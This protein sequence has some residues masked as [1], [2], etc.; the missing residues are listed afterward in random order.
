MNTR[1]TE[2]TVG[3]QKVR[4]GAYILSSIPNTE[5]FEYQLSVTV[6]KLPI[7]NGDR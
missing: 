6:T 2:L 5:L 4:M 1:L 7:L 3:I